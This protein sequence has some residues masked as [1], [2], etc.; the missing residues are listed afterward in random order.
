MAPLRYAMVGG[1]REA[2]ISQVHRAAM[3]LC[4]GFTLAAGALSA[5]PARARASGRDLGLPE[6][7]NHASWQDLLAHERALP[8]AERCD[9]VVIVTPNDLHYPVA[10]AFAE[11]GFH[12]VC[13]KPLVHTLAQA[14]ALAAVVARQR[15]VFGVTYNYSGHPMVAEARAQ[16]RA[17]AIGHVRK[18]IVEYHQGWLATALEQQG[19]KQAGWRTDPARA[20]AGAIADIGSH[21]EHLMRHVTGL[22]IEALCADLG[23]LVP[24]RRVDDDAVVQL[25]LH[26]G[27]RGVLMASQVATG[28][29]NELRLRVYGSAGALAWRLECPGELQL[30]SADGAARRLTPDSPGLLT[31][32]DAQFGTTAGAA[33][34]AGASPADAGLE[35]FA[36]LYRGIASAIR[37]HR[38]GV[39]ASLAEGMRAGPAERTPAG[40][41]PG[42]AAGFPDIH[43]GVLGVRF[44]E[45]ALASAAAGGTWVAL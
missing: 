45:R 35:A 8:A 11:A 41:S 43:D 5:D 15:I 18:V 10:L 28:C 31:R 39:P 21:A 27:A 36:N 1:G 16:V 34:A 40:P 4:G 13:D 3:A 24:G 17:G 7:R 12:V 29:G 14:E 19:H 32:L 37:A 2:M 22:A 33:G 9:A 26:G 23:T 42:E 38:S 20:G 44:I 6:A 30:C 25:R